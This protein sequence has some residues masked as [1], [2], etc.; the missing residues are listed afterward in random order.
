MLT[1]KR[2]PTI[3]SIYQDAEE[4]PGCGRNCLGRCCIPGANLPVYTFCRKHPLKE[5]TSIAGGIPSG[6]IS[7]SSSD[8]DGED[9]SFLDS[10][11]LAQWEERL[12]RGLFRYDVTACETKVLLGKFGFIA[13]LN[14]GRHLKKRPTEFRVDQV[15][16]AFDP[17]K[18]NFTKVG[19]EEVLFCFEESHHGSRVYCEKMIIGGSPNVIAIN[20]SPIE[21]GHVLLVPK[22][23]DCK[24]QQIDEESFRLAL[25]LA[26]EAQNPSFRVGY[27]SLGAFA[28]INHLHFQAYYLAVPFPVER[29]AVTKIATSKKKG[30]VKIFELSNY[31]VKGLLYEDG[32]NLE[33]L[34]TCV[35]RACIILQE[36]NIPFNVLIADCGHRVFLFPQCFAEKQALGL[37]DR[38]ILD[39]QV[40]PAVWE[41]SGHIVLKRRHDYESA[42]EEYAWKLLAEV[43]LTEERFMAVKELCLDAAWVQE[44]AASDPVPCEIEDRSFEKVTSKIVGS[45]S[46]SSMEIP[47]SLLSEECCG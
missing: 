21:Y 16:Q 22:A 32:G 6:C 11:L 23:L 36:R 15:L 2:I 31:A 34:A 3:V 42:T 41:I 29:A 19:Q 20:V 1:I 18:F 5:E 38:D 26:A 13:Q 44:D 47:R 35:A 7:D 37:V 45:G 39:T 4:Q 17:K 14:E 40:N 33:E 10:L 8:S 25:Y 43:S 46:K 30:G 28:T 24:P 12:T 27:N 9:S